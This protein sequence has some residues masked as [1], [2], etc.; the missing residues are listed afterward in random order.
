M[1]KPKLSIEASQSG[2]KGS[3]R[4]VDHIGAAGGSSSALIRNIVDGFLENNISETEVYINSKGGSTVEAT[5]IVNELKRLPK[6]NVKVGAVAASAATYIMA[7]F[8][9]AAYKSSQFMIHRP[10]MGTF[11]DLN[12]ITADMELLRNTTETYKTAY[13]EK[14]KKSP[15]EIEVIFQKGDYWMTAKKAKTEGLLNEIL[16]SE[17]K[18]TAEDVA[19]L[20]A[21]GAPVIPEKKETK[22][23]NNDDT[24][25]K[26]VLKSKLKL[27]ADATDA[28]IE[29]AIDKAVANAKEVEDLKETQKE[30][31]KANVEAM[32]DKAILDKKITADA[33]EQYIGF[34]QKDI[35]GIRGILDLMSPR[36]VKA[37]DELDRKGSDELASRKDWTLD[38]YLDK[39]PEAYEKLK[40]ESPKEAERIEK[41]YFN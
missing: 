31:L 25:D 39:D 18:I 37:S 5:E 15:E 10:R 36:A 33:R 23:K 26:N 6:V 16:A 14:M 12:Q 30:T 32:V 24:M 34:G 38:E 11:G 20:E 40:S 13:A 4:I 21:C 7:H 29:A 35:E 41:E 22:T 1:A 3:I 27:S 8:P 2:K 28:Q 19:V 17:N 9:S